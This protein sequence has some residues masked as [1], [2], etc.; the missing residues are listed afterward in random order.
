MQNTNRRQLA[1]GLAAGIGA[2]TVAGMLMGQD[3]PRRDPTQ[4]PSTQPTPRPDPTIRPDPMS[5]RGEYFVT[6]DA[7]HVSLWTRD[8]TSL[9]WL[10]SADSG[11]TDLTKPGDRPK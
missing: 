3:T 1:I 2:A 6:G 5:M 7:N 11:K 4:P 9:R 8:G 10:S